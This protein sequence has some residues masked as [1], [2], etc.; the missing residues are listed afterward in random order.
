[1]P[2]K[3]GTL[4]HIVSTRRHCDFHGTGL[5]A[6]SADHWPWV[7]RKTYFA[8]PHFPILTYH[9]CPLDREVI[10]DCRGDPEEL[11]LCA[12]S[13]PAPRRGLLENRPSALS[14]AAYEA[15]PPPPKVPRKSGW[16]PD[17]RC[18]FPT[19]HKDVSDVLIRSLIPWRSLRLSAA[20]PDVRDCVCLPKELSRGPL[21]R[22]IY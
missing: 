13:P 20:L 21:L 6:S 9:S 11:L 7:T 12:F 16:P 17:F 19:A 8:S 10:V 15:P 3:I 5:H 2:H 18:S 14:D 22:Q 4:R 1:V